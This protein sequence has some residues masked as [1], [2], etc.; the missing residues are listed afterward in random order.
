MHPDSIIY[1]DEAKSRK[2]NYEQGLM[3]EAF[4][5]TWMQ[6]GDSLYLTYIKRNLDYYIADD[7]TIRTYKLSDFN[8]DNIAPG[9]GVVRLYALTGQDKYRK[10]ADVLRDQL[11]QQPRTRSGGFWHKK[12]YPFQMWLDGLYMAEPFYTLYAATFGENKAFDDIAHQFLLIEKNNRD[13]ATG[14]YYHGWDESRSERWANPKTGRSA[15]FW[16]RSIGWFAMALVDVLELFPADHPGRTDLE[17]V[18]K[19]LARSVLHYRED[20]TGLWYQVID[21]PGEKGNYLEASASAMFAYALAKGA[22]LGYLPAEMGEKGMESF[23]GVLN[24]L[25]ETGDD[26]VI[27]LMKTVKVGGLG[28]K[29]YRDGSYDY[30]LSEPTRTDDFKGYGPFLLAAIETERLSGQLN[31]GGDEARGKGN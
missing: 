9:K 12:I 18:F 4:Y 20:S 13:E 30:Y 10:A 14:L 27:H 26:G 15:S 23:T 1:H 22:R 2:W 16:G 24:H 8:L 17:R 28:G 3:L 7:G 5:Q 11:R 21:K 19:D 29:P 25:T 31:N 6:S